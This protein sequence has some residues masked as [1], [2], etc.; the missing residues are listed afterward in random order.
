M[1]PMK[2]FKSMLI[3]AVCALDILLAGYLGII[4]F[5]EKILVSSPEP[6]PVRITSNIS[7]LF[8]SQLEDDIQ[9]Y[10][11]NYY[12]EGQQPDSGYMEKYV[13]EY[14]L[15]IDSDVFYT[16]IS[17]AADVEYEIVRQWYEQQ[18]KT[19]FES[20]VQGQRDGEA[21]ELYFYNEVL[22]L[23]GND[24][25]VRIA[26]RNFEILSFSCIQCREEDIRETQDWSEKKEVLM[27]NL[28][29]CAG[30]IADLPLYQAEQYGIWDES[31]GAHTYTQRPESY[32]VWGEGMDGNI[33]WYVDMYS[34]YLEELEYYLSGKLR[35]Q[36]LDEEN[37]GINLWK[38]E[39]EGDV[40][41]DQEET[42]TIQVIEQKDSILLVVESDVMMGI[43][44]DVVDQQVVGFHFF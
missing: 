6:E 25:N 23:D 29:D 40:Y 44:Y 8:Y 1:K 24:Y 12:V 19:I 15:Y 26:W 16:L 42:P 4:Y 21:L 30:L 10:P 34:L 11:W 20:M 38:E 22:Q 9:L 28:E 43:Y 35:V 33:Y 3:T 27:E 37:N 2:M 13:L 14:E 36:K 41:Y 39:S 5:G 32:G 7:N 17:M 31:S 18:K